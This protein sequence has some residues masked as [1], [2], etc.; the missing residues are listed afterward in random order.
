MKYDGACH[1]SLKTT[2]SSLS[3]QVVGSFEIVSLFIEFTML[4][5]SD[6]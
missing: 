6:T 1:I 4:V 2:D 3:E 5:C